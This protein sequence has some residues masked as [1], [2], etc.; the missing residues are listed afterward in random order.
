MKPKK[1][2][3]KQ[4]SRRFITFLFTC[5]FSIC[6]VVHLPIQAKADKTPTD[7]WN[8][9][10]N[11]CYGKI[12]DVGN[13]VDTAKTALEEEITDK[14]KQGI[15]DYFDD[16][17]A[18]ITNE[19][20]TIQASMDNQAS[21]QEEMNQVLWGGIWAAFEGGEA[22]G[23][24]FDTTDFVTNPARR[25]K[26]FQAIFIVFGYSLVLLFFAVSL[27]DQTIKYE[28]FTLRGAVNIFGRLLISKAIIDASSWVCTT[29]ITISESICT[30]MLTLTGETAIISNMPH[31]KVETS[32]IFIIGPIVD[33]LIANIIALP[34]NLIFLIILIS[35][36]LIMIK[37]LLRSF[38]LTMLTVVSPAFFA[39]VSSSTTV[40]YFK[41]F[42][43]TFLQAA[44]QI[45]FMAVVYFVAVEHIT[46]QS[47]DITNFAELATWLGKTLP[48]A[49]IVLAMA[50]MMVKPPRVLTGL[51]K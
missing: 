6:I 29:I 26:D 44:F 39:C 20:L 31:I 47:T 18:E 25:G 14:T 4:Q 12:A 2:K 10:I 17:T 16:Q 28:I 50:I 11:V 34:V 13:K 23:Y 19:A 48:N 5:F 15:E 8:E 40:P 51:I 22:L 37:L 3:I 41:N 1:Q 36:A 33:F 7:L 49:I 46:F 35:G 38:E 32:D 21:A 45:I 24:D 9:L 43:T 42:I 27:I 30:R